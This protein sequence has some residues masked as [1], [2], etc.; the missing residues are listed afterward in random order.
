MIVGFWGPLRGVTSC[1]VLHHIVWRHAQVRLF[2]LSPAFPPVH[3]SSPS[4]Y[5]D[6]HSEKGFCE[7]APPDRGAIHRVTSINM[8]FDTGAEADTVRKQLVLFT[9]QAVVSER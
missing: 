6:Y 7:Q 4:P 9:V 2:Y 5:L 3:R 1:P 8:T